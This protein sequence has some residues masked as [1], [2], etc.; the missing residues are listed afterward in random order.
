MEACAATKD[1][2]STEKWVP[3]ELDDGTRENEIL[4]DLTVELP[5]H[6]GS[7]MGEFSL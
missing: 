6:D 2:F 5:W 4:L 7:P 3:C 1:E